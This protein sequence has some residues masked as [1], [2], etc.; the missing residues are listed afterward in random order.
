MEFD[1]V[2][3]PIIFLTCIR[4]WIHLWSTVVRRLVPCVFLGWVQIPHALFEA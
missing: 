1:V 3:L 4:V 2:F